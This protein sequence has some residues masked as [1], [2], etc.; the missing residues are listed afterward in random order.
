MIA[1]LALVGLFAVGDMFHAHAA[2]CTPWGKGTCHACSSCSSCGN[3]AK[4]GGKCS[5]CK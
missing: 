3:C 5:V 4:R 2:T 1:A